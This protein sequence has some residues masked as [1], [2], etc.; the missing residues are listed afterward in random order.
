MPWPLQIRRYANALQRLLGLQGN[1]TLSIDDNIQPTLDLLSAH[2]ELYYL[3]GE[4]RFGFA[5]TSPAV[6][7]AFSGANLIAQSPRVVYAIERIVVINDT[8]G[9]LGYDLSDTGVALTATFQGLPLDGRLQ[10]PVPQVSSALVGRGSLAAGYTSLL[11]V[12][13]PAGES[14]DLVLG[15]ADRPV[16]MLGSQYQVFCAT[17]NTALHVAFVWREYQ[18][19]PQETEGG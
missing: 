19:A 10:Q 2:P 7:G 17:V 11:H 8:A 9:A 15:A 18:A 1:F 13:V 5:T 4:R 16:F 12:R 6:A 3:R 14:R